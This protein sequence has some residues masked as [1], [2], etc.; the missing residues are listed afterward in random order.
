MF[1]N[2]PTK[3]K[4]LMMWGLYS[5]LLLVVILMQS[6]YL[7]QF[8]LARV[9]FDLLPLLVSA[10]AVLNGA[11]CGGIFGLCAG[12]SWALSGG[13]D[14]GMTIVGLTVSGVLAGHLCDSVLT[15]RLPTAVLM[16]LM[17]LLLTGGSVLM[18][19]TYLGEG[20]LWGLQL[21]LR[22]TILSLPLS[23]LLYWVAKFIRKAGPENG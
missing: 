8:S 13:S 19:R 6:V 15:R 23:P 12:L 10:V 16:A 14:G 18:I 5:L 20:G 3:R 17:S 4:N 7:G 1:P 2:N 9:H 22:Q 11:E 21:L